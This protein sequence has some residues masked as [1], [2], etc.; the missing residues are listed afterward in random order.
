M[1]GRDPARERF[2]RRVL[3]R[4][5]RGGRTVREFCVAEGLK[6]SSFYFWKRELRARDGEI[7]RAEKPPGFRGANPPVFVPV[8]VTPTRS[9]ETGAALLEI[10]LE[11]GAMLRVPAGF[12]RETLGNVL[13]LLE[14]PR[15]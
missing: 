12:D 2:W 11:C 5:Q 8:V 10:V 13:E 4:Y 14:R 6:E 9:H 15:C 3:K 7:T 1:V